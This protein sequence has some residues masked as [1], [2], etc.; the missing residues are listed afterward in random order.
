MNIFKRFWKSLYSPADIASFRNDKIRK[1]VVYIIVLSF[2]TFL[3]LAYFTN[4]TTKNALKV[5]EETITNE[6]P[7]FKVTDGK[8]VLTDKNAK[9]YLSRL[10]KMNYIFILMLPEHW[11]RMT[12]IIKLLLMI[13]R[14]LFYQIVFILLQLVF[15]NLLVMTQQ[16]LVIRQIQF[17][18]IIRLSHQL[19]TLFQLLYQYS[20]SLRQARSSSEQ[21]CMRFSDLFFLDLAELVSPSAKI[22]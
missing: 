2:V 16:E 13:A 21:H 11:I 4:V 1:S 5:G 7:N 9:I 14:Q 6:I 3:P 12:Q 22:G 8:L 15:R 10:I 18:Y 19:N 17:I 20:L